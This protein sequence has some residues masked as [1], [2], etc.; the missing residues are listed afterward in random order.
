MVRPNGLYLIDL[1]PHGQWSAPSLIEIVHYNWPELLLSHKAPPKFA[2]KIT[3]EQRANMRNSKI[4]SM[5][6]VSDGTVYFPIGNGYT[7]SGLSIDVLVASDSLAYRLRNFE[8]YCRENVEKLVNFVSQE[9]GQ[10]LREV[11][12]EI[13]PRFPEQPL[14]AAEKVSQC[15]IHE[16]IFP[17]MQ[18]SRSNDID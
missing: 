7:C 2:N 18:I 1:M 10:D 4:N 3:Q 6:A 14:V 17:M 8:K 13:L 16:G 11:H 15:L 9:T 12:L 5:I